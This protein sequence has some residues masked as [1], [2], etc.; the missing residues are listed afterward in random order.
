MNIPLKDHIV[1]LVLLSLLAFVG[2]YFLDG[3]AE[4][5]GAGNFYKVHVHLLLLFNAMIVYWFCYKDSQNF[6]LSSCLSILYLVSPSHFDLFLFP[7]QFQ[8]LVAETFL[9]LFFMAYQLNLQV[10]S[11]IV[12]FLATLA[13]SKLIAFSPILCLSK[14]YSLRQKA[15]LLISFLIY[16]VYLIPLFTEQKE[17]L[18]KSS[19]T[20]F[21]IGE[22]LSLNPSQ[23]FLNLALLTPDYHSGLFYAA[24]TLVVLLGCWIL[25][26]KEEWR[27]P[28]FSL[29]FVA[30]LGSIIPFKQ[31][32]RNEEHLY[33]LT[34]S[35]Y[36]NV[37]FLFLL[38]L[39][40]LLKKIERPKLAI[41]SAG[42]LIVLW[43]LLGI[44]FQISHYDR[45]IAWENALN[46]LPK[47]FNFEEKIKLKFAT[48]LV[49]KGDDQRAL[50]FINEAKQKFP[51]EIWY[52]MLLN[53]ASKKQD[54]Q[55]VD[56]VYR[57][58]AREQIPFNNPA[59][60]K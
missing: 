38:A 14:K 49:E 34:S 26:K 47:D 43:I 32:S 15:F 54:S 50:A 52:A 57:D 2:M 18:L 35:L 9:L 4:A 3:F 6:A 24:I 59:F 12:F 22:I 37:L 28:A 56:Q 1:Y 8:A 33:F 21:Y 51:R 31:F 19:K 44:N 55:A 5:I 23:S 13:N 48:V 29:L 42:S 25:F 7:F 60:E 16:L 27:I 40:N 58:M 20:I 39:L 36:P 41:Y 46:R 45:V 17:F 11:L 30:F 10:R 53:L